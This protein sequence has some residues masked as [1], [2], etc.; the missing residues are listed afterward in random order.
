MNRRAREPTESYRASWEAS[1]LTSVKNARGWSERARLVAEVGFVAGY[2][3]EEAPR[4]RTGDAQ[5]I[6]LGLCELPRIRF[7]VVA[8]LR[9][10]CLFG[11]AQGHP[12]E[13]QIVGAIVYDGVK[14]EF[15]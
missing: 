1:T 11:L 9:G 4:I 10:S 12:L 5:V 6:G 2:Y 8:V 15:G 3:E 13:A 7:L 14:C